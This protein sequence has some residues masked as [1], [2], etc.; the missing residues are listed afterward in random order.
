VGSIKSDQGI[1]AHGK[2]IDAYAAGLLEEAARLPASGTAL[3]PASD[4]VEAID[5]LRTFG[6]THKLSLAG[7]TLRELR[8]E[9]RP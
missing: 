6:H 9:A 8:H 2:R 4:V 1:A 5:R 7:L 3:P